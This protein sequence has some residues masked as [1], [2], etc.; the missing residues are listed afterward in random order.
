MPR[1]KTGCDHILY[2]LVTKEALQVLTKLVARAGCGRPLLMDAL[3]KRAARQPLPRV[4]MPAYTPHRKTTHKV[5]KATA[6]A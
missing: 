4:R 6:R 3:I 5:L 2:T 1:A